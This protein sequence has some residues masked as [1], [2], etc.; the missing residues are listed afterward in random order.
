MVAL[1]TLC[2]V[3]IPTLRGRGARARSRSDTSTD[4]QVEQYRD[5]R[6]NSG[7]LSEYREEEVLVLLEMIMLVAKVLMEVMYL[8]IPTLRG[9]GRGTRQQE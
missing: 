2:E 9:R 3:F 1:I 6:E 4:E 8:S 7:M 5:G